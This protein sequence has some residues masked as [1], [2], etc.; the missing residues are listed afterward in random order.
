LVE[1][2]R[3]NAWW[4]RSSTGR[5]FREFICGL[6]IP[7]CDVVELEAVKLVF[8]RGV[9]AARALHDLVDHELGVASNVEVSDPQFDGDSQGRDECL[10]FGDVVRCRKMKPDDIA[11]VNP[12]G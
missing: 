9:W 6:I 8:H 10:V 7:A 1:V 5:D 4:N 12:K 3:E 11:H 2:S